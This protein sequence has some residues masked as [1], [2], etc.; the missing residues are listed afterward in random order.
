M[1]KQA[2]TTIAQV[3]GVRLAPFNKPIALEIAL[4]CSGCKLNVL[5]NL[6]QAVLS[7]LLRAVRLA[8]SSLMTV[9]HSF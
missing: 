1:R 5:S 8:L 7:R 6:E 3:P 4:L 2:A 9:C